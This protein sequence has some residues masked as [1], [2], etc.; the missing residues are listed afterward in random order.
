M[1]SWLVA[2]RLARREARRAKGRTA[3]IIAMICLPV[4]ALAFAATTLDMQRLTPQEQATRVMG[5]ADGILTYNGAN[6]QREDER[7]AASEFLVG[8]KGPP[9]ATATVLSLLPAGASASWAWQG[10]VSVR[11]G[12]GDA[13]IEAY[14]LDAASPITRGLVHVSEG[15]APRTGNEV[16]MSQDAVT[17]LGTRVGG[18]ITTPGGTSFVVVGVAEVSGGVGAAMLF[19]S[20]VTEPGTAGYWLVDQPSPMLIDQIH[21]LNAAGYEAQS[22][23][24]V[25][26]Y[27]GQQSIGSEGSVL[28]GLSTFSVGTVVIG[29]GLVEVVLLA[30]PAFAVGA[31]RRQR[32]LALV[33]T[34][35]G[36]PSVLRRIVLADGIV[37]GVVAAAVGVIGGVGAAFALRGLLEAHLWHSRFGGYRVNPGWLAVIAAIAIGTGL[38]GALAP[39]ITASRQEIVLALAG[40]RGARHSRLRWSFGGAGLIGFG[41]VTAV[42]GAYQH[43]GGVV[44]TGLISGEFGIVLVTPTIVGWIA[45]LGRFLPLAPRIALRDA[46]RRRAAAAPAISAVM[47]AVAGTIAVTVYLGSTAGTGAT[48]EPGAPAGTVFVLSDPATP[49]DGSPVPA[50]TPGGSVR[51][52]RPPSV[53]GPSLSRPAVGTPSLGVP[54][55]QAPTGDAIATAELRASLA[56]V[57]PGAHPVTYTRLACAG[58][59]PCQLPLILPDDQQC[60]YQSGPMLSRADQRRARADARCVTNESFFGGTGEQVVT[61]DPDLVAAITGLRGAKLDAAVATLRDGGVLTSDA[62]FVERGHAV[63]DTDAGRAIAAGGTS[64]RAE[65]V[66][67]TVVPMGAPNEIPMISPALVR[68]VHG[69][70]TARGLVLRLPSPPSQAQ[71]DRLRKLIDDIDGRQY[72]ELG[73]PSP[74]SPIPLLLAIAAGVIALGAAGIATGLAAAESRH[75]LATLAAVG[76]TPRLRR[77]LSLAQAGIIAG[78]GAVL[79]SIAGFGAAAAIL[80][81]INQQW[82]QTWPGPH[83]LRITVPW[84][85]FGVSLVVVPIV[86]MAAAGLLT[87]SRLP[88]ERRPG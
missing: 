80:T 42:Y 29:L 18:R 22:R 34:N 58:D 44:L 81:G 52:A 78:L 65:T 40:R 71:Q 64:V 21:R 38:V 17:R 11:T 49:R 47:A 43:S 2:L 72:I 76:A 54:S 15:R 53:T 32:D 68:Q 57:F 45:R 3:L 88:S 5:A 83:L 60:P 25:L 8:A 4:F 59:A 23:A 87:R 48:Y 41:V 56:A 74:S 86:A 1:T 51:A 26:R 30:G 67:A 7:L 82:A 10:S 62:A 33:A 27:P 13:S 66:P 31:R 85:N 50:G 77:A 70:V 84:L 20:S 63:I 37:S 73:H 19:T 16:A 69:Q 24:Y 35:G 46:S 36:T 79:G 12:A 6:T 28:P 39:A 14:G 55:L 9:A 61:E 75:D